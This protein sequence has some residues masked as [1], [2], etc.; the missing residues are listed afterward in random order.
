M[1]INNFKENYEGQYNIA[2]YF[3]EDKGNLI[4][5][6][7][8]ILPTQNGEERWFKRDVN[9]NVV[10]LFGCFNADKIKSLWIEILN[11]LPLTISANNA[12]ISIHSSI[13][14]SENIKNWIFPLNDY[15]YRPQCIYS[16]KDGWKNKKNLFYTPSN[17]MIAYVESLFCLNKEKF[18][19]DSSIF[20]TLVQETGIDFFQDQASRRGNIEWYT[21]PSGNIQ[22]KSYIHIEAIKW[23][24]NNIISCRKTR[25]TFKSNVQGDFLVNVR[26]VNG[27]AIVCDITKEISVSNTEVFI[28]FDASEEISSQRV[29]IWKKNSASWILWY[30]KEL[31]LV[32]T[33]CTQLNVIESSVIITSEKL[34]KINQP[35]LK[36]RVD[37]LKN[38]SLYSKVSD[39]VIDQNKNDPWREI[40]AQVDDKIRKS[41]PKES[42]SLF[43]PKGWDGQ[44]EF[45]EWLKKLPSK[46]RDLKE[47][48]IV[49]PY[50]E[51]EVLKFI[52]RFENTNVHYILVANT[53]S[54][55]SKGE[56]NSES[57]RKNIITMA[58]RLFINNT[59]NSFNITI[60]D[61]AKDKQLIHDRY[62]LLKDCNGLFIKGF[63]LSNSIQGANVSYP[64]LITEIPFDVIGKIQDWLNDTL[65]SKS[66]EPA[67]LELLWSSK[68]ISQS[69]KS[70]KIA[71]L[72]KDSYPDLTED[73]ITEN[74]IK[75]ND[76]KNYS[77]LKTY[78]NDICE[79]SYNNNIT[80]ENFASASEKFSVELW[81]NIFKGVKEDF[82]IEKELDVSDE[83]L[84]ILDYL[85]T[86]DFEKSIDFAEA[87]FDYLRP[88]YAIPPSLYFLVYLSVRVN[89]EKI[90]KFSEELYEE[91]T[92]NKNIY[93]RGLFFHKIFESLSDFFMFGDADEAIWLN[94]KI[95]LMIGFTAISLIK[96]VIH[97]ALDIDV[98]IKKIEYI[99]QNKKFS[100]LVRWIYELRVMNNSENEDFHKKIR[101]TIF[102]KIIEIW[103]SKEDK[104]FVKDV[105]IKCGGRGNG[106]FA[107]STTTELFIPLIDNKKISLELFAD[108]INDLCDAHLNYEA[109]YSDSDS[110]DVFEVFGFIVGKLDTSK[111]AKELT[112]I[113][114][115]EMRNISKPFSISISYKNYSDS[116]EKLHK[117]LIITTCINKY[118]EEKNSET[119]KLKNIILQKLQNTE[120]LLTT[121]NTELNKTTELYLKI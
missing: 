60:Y 26:C 13:K 47:L 73:E 108:S 120:I 52:P 41:F 48:W 27:N 56:S 25:V 18:F 118:L 3:Y 90:L 69:I 98:A 82:D 110:L 23:N 33:I 116:L 76:E 30:E 4:L 45:Y 11:N 22:D 8:W 65:I 66:N 121:S 119:E 107:I 94:S 92:D 24:E 15:T 50:I 12:N 113:S 64:L 68:E 105:L 7:S 10:C 20:K 85:K 93:L 37:T 19:F 46:V 101:N 16:A 111:Y 40:I 53:K 62:I 9:K 117:I 104:E 70:R 39:R 71:Y 2:F 29:L 67:K 1:N 97:N 81:N 99:E 84:A 80:Q 6:Y 49:D 5:L 74:F 21:I 89:P 88:V 79:N 77:E 34:N 86:T 36:T 109:R 114:N 83:T 75:F 31:P 87:I 72:P 106:N 103:S 51:E 96:K 43:L 58:Q 63:H 32:R 35:N 55:R 54:P 59:L 78:W 42:E 38:A 61:V 100:I 17:N 44:I 14:L 57:I 112:K 95:D 102:G 115:I 91:L 28:D